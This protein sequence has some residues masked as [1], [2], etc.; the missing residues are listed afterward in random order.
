M[1]GRASKP[2]WDKLSVLS[3]GK[4]FM[5]QVTSRSGTPATLKNVSCKW[6]G[7]AMLIKDTTTNR[8]NRTVK[9]QEKKTTTK[10]KQNKN[11]KVGI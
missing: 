1:F 10:N 3:M 2:V 8:Y 11:N 7:I 9:F 6:H 5:T 4:L